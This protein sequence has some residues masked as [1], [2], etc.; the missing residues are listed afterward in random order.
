MHSDSGHETE[1]ERERETERERQRTLDKTLFDEGEQAVR[2][3]EIQQIDARRINVCLGITKR[4][5][6]LRANREKVLQNAQ[7]D[8]LR[9]AELL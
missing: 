9:V 2:E 7:V 4:S 6:M 5:Q 1:R 3:L 8:G